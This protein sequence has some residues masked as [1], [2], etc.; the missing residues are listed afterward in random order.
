MAS[1]RKKW[2]KPLSITIPD[3]IHATQD[4]SD[5]ELS[6]FFDELRRLGIHD[7]TVN[8]LRS[9]ADMPPPIRLAVNLKS[10]I[11]VYA[12]KL[13]V[14]SVVQDGLS[15]VEES[16]LYELALKDADSTTST[17]A[18]SLLHIQER[19]ALQQFLRPL[20]LGFKLCQK[21]KIKK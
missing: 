16:A 2:F 13:E 3:V 11:D 15:E 18:Q 21:R 10:L 8:L 5:E 17:I 7:R 14:N 6:D 4:V 1:D 20:F 9:R 19:Y 12:Q